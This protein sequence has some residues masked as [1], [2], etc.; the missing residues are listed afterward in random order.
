MRPGFYLAETPEGSR[1]VIDAVEILKFLECPPARPGIRYLNRLIAAYTRNVPWES[2]SRIARRAATTRLADCPRGPAEFWSEAMHSGSG[3]T[4]YESNDAFLTLLRIIGF[5]GYL[6]VNDMGEARGCHAACIIQLD[7]RKY[8]ADVGYPNP[9]A[10]PVDSARITRRSTW[11]HTYTVRPAGRF[12][13]EIERSRHPFRNLYTLY[14]IPIH[15]AAYRKIVEQDYG[16]NGLFLNRV[17]IVKMVNGLLWRFNSREVPYRLEGFGR[18]EKQV[19]EIPDEEITQ[20][21]AGHFS[22]RESV[23]QAAFRAL[24]L[25]SG[26]HV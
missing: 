6:T 11:L 10:L 15:E 26:N 13:Y 23:L 25:P 14:D 24:N 3:G 12:R 22:M 17:V 21:L 5:S 7:G 2:A 4:C 8:L 20:Q 9:V 1:V 16:E 19:I 18:G